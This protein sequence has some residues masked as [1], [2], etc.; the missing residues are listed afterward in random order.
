MNQ[1]VKGSEEIQWWLNKAISFIWPELGE[2]TRYVQIDQTNQIQYYQPGKVFQW[3]NFTTGTTSNQPS[4]ED[5][6]KNVVFH[7]IG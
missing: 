3:V 5:K 6:K 2:V 4:P 7:I 1:L